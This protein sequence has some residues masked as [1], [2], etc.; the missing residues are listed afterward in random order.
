MVASPTLLFDS[1]P[2]VYRIEESEGSGTSGARSKSSNSTAPLSPG[3][4]L[5]YTTPVLVPSLCKA[6]C[7]A[8]RVSL[9]MSPGLSASIVEVASMT[10]L[11]FR[12]RFR[13]SYDSS[14]LPTLLV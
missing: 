9:A 5:T 4:P 1:T 11:A 10:D 13:S 7:M 3:H 14:S 8:M 12:K 6:T 2:P